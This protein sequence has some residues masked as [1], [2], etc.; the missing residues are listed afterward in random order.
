[1]DTDTTKVALENVLVLFGLSKTTSSIL[2]ISRRS[3]GGN[4]TAVFDFVERSRRG[5]SV[6]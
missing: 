6:A 4:D 1:V 5:K 2:F 3:S